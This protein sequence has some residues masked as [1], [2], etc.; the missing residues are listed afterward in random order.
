MPNKN[1]LFLLLLFVCSVMINAQNN[2]SSP[3]SQFGLGERQYNPFLQNSGMGELGTGIRLSNG[4]N[5]SNPAT[6]NNSELVNY[7]I[8]V[9]GTFAQQSDGVNYQNTVNAGLSHFAICLPLG[10]KGGLSFG[11]LPYSRLGYEI[12]EEVV[13]PEYGKSTTSYLGDGDIS[14]FYVGSALKLGSA[15]S[16]G[17]NVSYYF[18]SLNRSRTSEFDTS[19]NILH[20]RSVDKDAIGDLSFNYGLQYVIEKGEGKALKKYVFGYS[21]ALKSGLK[22]SKTVY[23]ERYYKSG[24]V[25]IL[26]DS[27]YINISDDQTVTLPSYHS[28]G[29]SY[30]NKK[31]IGGF[32]FSLINWAEVEDSDNSKIKLQNTYRVAAGMQTKGQLQRTGNYLK[33]I[34]TRVGVGYS[35]GYL[36][37]NNFLIS[38]KYATIGFGFPLIK[39]ASFLNLGVKYSQV[40]TVKNNLVK[41]DIISVSF[42]LTISDKWFV[43]R[44]YD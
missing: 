26:V 4:F 7:E 19:S 27:I 3:Y 5:A 43:K 2:T 41:E 37:V 10:K 28:I 34:V 18:G 31:I 35:P 11:L 8:G 20:L 42:G 32:D 6:Y 17:A 30:E 24:S 16:I 29:F 25:D 39:S 13:V 23:T 9:F 21:G 44:Q 22:T 36:N 12:S 33:S 40:G 14:Q 38:E 15:L 1:Y